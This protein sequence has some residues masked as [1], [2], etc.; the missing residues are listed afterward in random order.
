MSLVD[1]IERNCAQARVNN[2]F[3]ITGARQRTV[4]HELVLH[5]FELL[6]GQRKI[7]IDRSIF[8]DSSYTKAGADRRAGR[9]K[10]RSHW[11][12]YHDVRGLFL[13]KRPSSTRLAGARGEWS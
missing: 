5:P 1:E 11:T 8:T 3:N 4:L 13:Y 12:N 6:Q 9:P 2:C 7:G 10:V